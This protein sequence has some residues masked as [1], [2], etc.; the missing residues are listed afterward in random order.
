MTTD[1]EQ[2]TLILDAIDRF[3]KTEVRPHVK[4][5]EQ[6]D[7]YPAEIVVVTN[8][9]ADHLDFFG[10]AEAYTQVFDDFVERLRPGGA[11]VVC[12]DDPA[13][14]EIL[15]RI[16]RQAFGLFNA[17]FMNSFFIA[18]I[19]APKFCHRFVGYL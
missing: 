5:L 15:P 7:E 1:P 11:L 6:A 2:E 8:I 10:S 17:I 16:A 9:E 3:L 12:V 18:Y 19:M 13:I 14:R 4:R